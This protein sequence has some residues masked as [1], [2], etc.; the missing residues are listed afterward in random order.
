[1]SM[2]AYLVKT[3]ELHFRGN[4]SRPPRLRGSMKNPA[5]EQPFKPAR[6]NSR[7]L[8]FRSRRRGRRCRRGSLSGLA[9]HGMAMES[10]RVVPRILSICCTPWASQPLFCWLGMLEKVRLISGIRKQQP[11]LP[12][13]PRKG[14]PDAKFS[15]FTSLHTLL[16]TALTAFAAAL[17]GTQYVRVGGQGP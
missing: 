16:A 11:G 4:L 9:S 6:T 5:F 10:W 2:L 12:G 8:L 7:S 13:K 1:M 3:G 17:T 15:L 14:P